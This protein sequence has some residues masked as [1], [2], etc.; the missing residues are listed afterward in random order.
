[1]SYNMQCICG[2]EDFKKIFHGKHK[3]KIAGQ[4][5]HYIHFS[6]LE[7]VSC[8]LTQTYPRPYESSESSEYYQEGLDLEYRLNDIQTFRNYAHTYLDHIAVYKKSGKIL[9]IGSSIG[10]TLKVAQE[11]GYEVLGVDVNKGAAAKARELFSIEVLTQN[12][13]E[14]SHKLKDFDIVILMHV[15][16]HIEDPPSFLKQT[17]KFLKPDGLLFIGVPNFDSLAAERKQAKWGGL[18]P[19]RHLWQFTPGSLQKILDK[20]GLK[21][22]KFVLNSNMNYEYDLNHASWFERKRLSSLLNKAKELHRGDNL[23]CV[24]ELSNGHL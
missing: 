17:V 24:A 9:E 14:L 11:R 5:K 19:M 1:M 13:F 15:L 20:A 16:E 21:V 8:S 18:D 6:V 12:I 7:C 23:F 22:R 4:P 3:K 10:V 2:S